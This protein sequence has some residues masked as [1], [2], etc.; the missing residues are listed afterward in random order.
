[1]L[2]HCPGR[3]RLDRLGKAARNEMRRIGYGAAVELLASPLQTSLAADL[4]GWWQSLY[5]LPLPISSAAEFDD[6]F[7]DSRHMPTGYHSVLA[8]AHA[9]LPVAVEDY[10][11]NGG[12]KLWVVRIPEGERQEGFLPRTATE[13]GDGSRLRDG[14]KLH[15][16]CT[17]KGVTTV[18]PIPEIG[19]IALPDLER[20]QVPAN[21]PDIP[22][23]QFDNPEPRFL[24]C[25]G[26]LADERLGPPPPA[27]EPGGP[28]TPQP[29]RRLIEMVQGTL[30]RH[31]PDVQ[32]LYSLPLAY[33]SHAGSPVVDPDVLDEIRLMKEGA[34]GP[35]LRRIQL[36]SPYM[37]GPRHRLVSA[38]GL[39]A[40]LQAQVARRHGMWRSAAAVP[41]LT[42]G[43]P[44][45]PVSAAQAVALREDPGVGVIRYRG[46]NVSLDDERLAV[47]ALHWADYGHAPDLKRFDDYR[48]GEVA[49]FLGFLMRQ[50]RALG[51]LIVFNLD[52]RDPRPRILL[53]EFFQRLYRAGAL[54]GRLP[55]DAFDI[56]E[57]HPREG[58]MIYEIEVA[59]AFPIDKLQ[60]TFSNRTGEW[61]AELANG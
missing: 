8:G 45:P 47:P 21:L 5:H 36:V 51:E 56:R 39:V 55:E 50:L 52:F 24:P 29:S 38:V 22:S 13:L 1:M 20:L 12:E 53:E 42:D 57:R 61:Q 9:W 11:A 10:F 27:G 2:G 48:S 33:S 14:T 28:P 60:L 4:S 34:T 3:V 19:V 58:T 54:R 40:G 49:R 32:C 16:V 44:Y 25:S 17:L 43:R 59:P 31:R 35:G 6:I 37:R 23:V 30:A 41:M 18:L 26:I 46:G 15:D 7:P